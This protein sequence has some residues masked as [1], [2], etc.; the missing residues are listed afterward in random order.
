MK[1]GIPAG[2][3]FLFDDE[4]RVPYRPEESPEE[5]FFYRAPR[6]KACERLKQATML[7]SR[8]SYIGT[9]TASL[10][11]LLSLLENGTRTLGGVLL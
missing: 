9:R 10:G 5:L 8:D 2:W 4:D 3:V 1:Y 11:R 6:Q 7:L